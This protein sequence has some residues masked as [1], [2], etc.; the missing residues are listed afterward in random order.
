MWDSSTEYRHCLHDSVCYFG[1]DKNHL[2]PCPNPSE[3]I[4]EY[5]YMCVCVCVWERGKKKKLRKKVSS[6]D[7]KI[8][9]SVAWPDFEGYK[10]IH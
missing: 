6:V 7:G 2:G 5:I 9:G 10:Q 1:P 8:G 4:V 3:K